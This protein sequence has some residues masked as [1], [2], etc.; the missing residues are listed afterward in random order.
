MSNCHDVTFIASSP[1]LHAQL[2]AH[3][4]YEKSTASD[5]S[6]AWRLGNEAR[7]IQFELAE[8]GAHARSEL[9]LYPSQYLS[10][11]TMPWFFHTLITAL[12]SGTLAARHCVKKCEEYKSGC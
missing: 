2:L 11:V 8:A 7:H 1:G 3:L 9:A 6:W 5:K 4:Q 12:S 10:E